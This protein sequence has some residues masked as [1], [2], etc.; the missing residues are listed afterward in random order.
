MRESEEGFAEP[1][2]KGRSMKECKKYI[3]EHFRSW[4]WKALGSGFC[5][6]IEPLEPRNKISYFLDHVSWYL[7]S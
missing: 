6:H 5:F 4:G 3:N 7:A 1:A 2:N